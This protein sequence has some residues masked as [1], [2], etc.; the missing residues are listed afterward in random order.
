MTDISGLI[1][2]QVDK[3]VFGNKRVHTF[4]GYVGNGTDS[5]P[6]AGVQCPASNFG[7]REAEFVEVDGGTLKY[8]YQYSSSCVQAYTSTLSGVNCVVAAAVVPTSGVAVRFRA[9]GYGV[10]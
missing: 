5:W 7:L 4:T 1:L 10:A 3:T 6:A 9:T 8:V 2:T